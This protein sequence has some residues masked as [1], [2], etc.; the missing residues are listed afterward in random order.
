MLVVLPYCGKDSSLALKLLK[1]LPKL[2][3]YHSHQA[4]L[5]SAPEARTDEIEE[6][7]FACFPNV[8]SFECRPYVEGWP[9]GPNSMFAWA[10]SHVARSLS[11][12]PWYF[13]E[14]DNTPTTIGWL[15]QLEAEYDSAGKPFMGVVTPTR[16]QRQGVMLTDGEHMVGSGIYPPDAA[17]RSP[18]FPTIRRTP[19]PWD[20]YWQWDILPHVARTDKI[21]HVVRVKNCERRGRSYFCHSAHKMATSARIRSR[22][23]L[24]VHG[25][26]DGSL[27]DLLGA[28]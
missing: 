26:K 21:Q 7:A 10:A 23:A 13:F 11:P 6:A 4:L 14:P 15:D 3:P 19:F 27:I 28:G 2:G 20:V 25:V 1:F 12:S 22:S 18:L 16:L 24:V 8:S 5:I 9:Q 17:L